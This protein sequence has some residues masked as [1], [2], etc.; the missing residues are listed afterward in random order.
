MLRPGVCLCLNAPPALRPQGTAPGEEFT[1]QSLLVGHL[2]L[3]GRRP[4]VLPS[5]CVGRSAPTPWEA[6][7][8]G[9]CPGTS[10]AMLQAP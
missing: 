2:R 3:L 1:E 6:T 5:P 10:P 7:P 9:T 4:P 8:L